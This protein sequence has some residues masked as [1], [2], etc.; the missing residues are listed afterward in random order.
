M[1]PDSRQQHERNTIDLNISSDL[2]WK[3]HNI[4]A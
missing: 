4:A 2:K 1:S 3:G